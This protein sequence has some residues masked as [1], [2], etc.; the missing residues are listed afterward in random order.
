[1]Q[2]QDDTRSSSR[3]RAYLGSKQPFVSH[4]LLLH[5][6]KKIWALTCP[7]QSRGQIHR[8]RTS[9]HPCCPGSVPHRRP[10]GPSPRCSPPPRAGPACSSTETSLRVVAGA[11]AGQSRKVLRV[12]RQ[13]AVVPV[14]L[15]QPTAAVSHAVQSDLQGSG[16]HLFGSVGHLTAEDACGQRRS[17]A[18]EPSSASHTL[19]CFRVT[20]A[21]LD[22]GKKL[23]YVIMD[24]FKEK[25]VLWKTFYLL[26][27]FCF[28]SLF[29]SAT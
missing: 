8:S 12:S 3:A 14:P 11:S 20:S 13:T 23:F 21:E 7:E 16:T 19:S 22:K 29:D 15:S 18:A 2:K 26:S 4:A 1:M 10:P 27:N 17:E 9:L 6:R 5:F 28:T 24:F 25:F